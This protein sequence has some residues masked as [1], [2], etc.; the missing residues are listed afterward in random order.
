MWPVLSAYGAD[1]AVA[2][3]EG[4]S[5]GLRMTIADAG[6]SMRPDV[7]AMLDAGFV[8]VDGDEK[9]GV[10]LL[11][12]RTTFALKEL[13][14][15]LPDFNAATMIDANA[16]VAVAE[17][18]RTK[19]AAVESAPEA[20][21]PVAPLAAEP[22]V[23]TPKIPK[24]P[25]EKKKK[26]KITDA[27]EKIGRARKDFYG[28]RIQASDLAKMDDKERKQFIKKAVIWPYSFKEAKERGVSCGVANFI[29]ELRLAMPDMGITDPVKVTHEVF[30]NGVDA[31]RQHIDPVKTPVE[32]VNA[33][34]ALKADPGWTAYMTAHNNS[35]WDSRSSKK[36]YTFRGMMGFG[37]AEI[38]HAL[39][40]GKPI[41]WSLT[42]Y[43]KS[44]DDD[45]NAANI[46]FWWSRK[47][48]VKTSS[49]LSDMREKREEGPK[50]PSRPH[51]DSLR[52]DWLLN[53]DVTAEQLMSRFGFRAVEFGEWLPQGERQRVLNEAYGACAALA[54]TLG[55]PEKMVSLNGVLA[56]AFGSRGKGKAAAHFEPDLKVFNLTRMNGAGSMAHEWAH[57]LDNHIAQHLTGRGD[58]FISGMGG[59]RSLMGITHLDDVLD[60]MTKKADTGAWLDEKFADLSRAINWA[61]SWL[62]LGDKRDEAIK[63]IR[64]EVLLAAGLGVNP[65]DL[66]SP[67][68]SRCAKFDL[69]KANRIEPVKAVDASDTA[70]TVYARLRTALQQCFG[71]KLRDDPYEVRNGKDPSKQFYMNLRTAIRNARS[72]HDYLKNPD[73]AATT[74]RDSQFLENAKKL[75][76]KKSKKYYTE[77]H[78]MLARA[79]EC[80]VYDKLE[81]SGRPCDYLVHS[82]KGDLFRNDKYTG[83]PYPSGE[84]RATINGKMAE[85]ASRINFLVSEDAALAAALSD[86]VPSDHQ[87]RLAERALQNGADPN[88]RYESGLLLFEKVASR[89]SQQLAQLLIDS[90]LDANALDVRLSAMLM[91]EIAKNLLERGCYSVKDGIDARGRNGYTTLGYAV[92]CSN[93]DVMRA[94][95]DAGA[96]IDAPA[97]RGDLDF[98]P[99]ELTI[100][101]GRGDALPVITILLDAGATVTERSLA[102]AR[103][104]C[105]DAVCYKNAELV[106]LLEREQGKRSQNKQHMKG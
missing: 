68:D 42:R 15:W 23:K 40:H 49:Q 25:A 32:L 71:V 11:P 77:P 35:W 34:L 97:G 57:A 92:Q 104:E 94:L 101:K 67:S 48:G 74:D 76:S 86:A 64:D 65:D 10:F 95:I 98:T 24:K 102:L 4:K 3:Q 28:R 70:A 79:F 47:L 91:P 106:D 90:G 100:A 43:N 21:Q 16:P 27:G 85:F 22:E 99:L 96:D 8:L 45:A 84:E 51:L 105:A 26:E 19:P 20:H 53:E 37:Q 75:D 60:A 54:D 36:I 5:I 58:S 13:K 69:K 61:S 103:G 30:I 18:N 17:L 12:G 89:S 1:I 6:Q 55:I 9:S 63:M 66:P 31:L 82:V 81:E 72:L 52:N 62:C 93:Q 14:A 59:N 33:L 38:D 50:E 44:L 56:A 7:R 29:K 88:Q 78:E 73:V 87:L 46:A 83:N 2:R 39:K 80:F 41:T